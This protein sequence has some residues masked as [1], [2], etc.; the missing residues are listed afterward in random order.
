MSNYSVST[1]YENQVG[2]VFFN[3][4]FSESD[5][6]IAKNVNYSTSDVTFEI[7]NH[8]GETIWSRN[9][10]NTHGYNA[11]ALIDLEIAAK[12]IDSTAIVQIDEIDYS[13][14]FED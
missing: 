5:L 9:Y 4:D 8:D 11:Q 2:H 7:V 1:N 14:S 13:E 10:P 3:N 6:W 12:E